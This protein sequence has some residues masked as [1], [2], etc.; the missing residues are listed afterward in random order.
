VVVVEQKVPVDV[1]KERLDGI[2]LNHEF[3]M[4][5]WNKQ[6]T[7]GILQTGMVIDVARAKQPAVVV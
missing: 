5:K 3:V 6:H 4:S 1:K 7:V 2:Q